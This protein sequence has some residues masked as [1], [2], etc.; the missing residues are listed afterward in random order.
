VTFDHGAA[1]SLI[2]YL[3]SGEK[4]SGMTSKVVYNCLPPEEWDGELPVR[5]SFAH[6]YPAQV[7]ERVI[8]NWHAYGFS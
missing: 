2:A 5:S 7:R 8:A 6:A 3:R 4:M 1:P